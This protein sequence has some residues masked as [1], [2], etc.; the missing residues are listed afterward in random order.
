MRKRISMEKFS[1]T[2][3]DNQQDE[4]NNKIG[5]LLNEARPYTSPEVKRSLP[6]KSERLTI[7]N[8]PTTNLPSPLNKDLPS[9]VSGLV[10]KRTIKKR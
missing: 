3:D 8:K 10:C 4:V 1:N 2:N 5:Y 9:C 6:L 7:S